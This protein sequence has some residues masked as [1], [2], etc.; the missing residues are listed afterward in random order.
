MDSKR[1]G[2]TSDLVAAVHPQ[3]GTTT[4]FVVA[5][6][7]GKLPGAGSNGE[8]SMHHVFGVVSLF[9]TRHSS[10]RKQQAQIAAGSRFT[11]HE[12]C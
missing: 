12:R 6:V 3:K 10:L 1:S 11:S 9:L 8:Q 2:T 7:K 5:T 4:L